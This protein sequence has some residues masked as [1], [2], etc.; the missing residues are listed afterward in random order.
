LR[1]GASLMAG[2]THSHPS[3]APGFYLWSETF[4]ALADMLL[5]SGWTKLETNNLPVLVNPDR[6][7]GVITSSGSKETGRSTTSPIKQNTGPATV[8]LV[9]NNVIKQLELPVMA[10]ASA[11]APLLQPQFPWT[12]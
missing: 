12:T 3:S 5:P 7:V 10:T 4:S 9:A 1:S 11:A 8:T 2:C 6:T